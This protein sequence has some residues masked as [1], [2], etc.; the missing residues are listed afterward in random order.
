[1]KKHFPA[2]IHKDPKSDYGVS[3]PDFPGC[4]SAGSTVEEALAM[5]EEALGGHVALMVE[6]GDALPDPS[7]V[8]EVASALDDHCYIAMVPAILPG[9]QKRV[10]ISMDTNLL[11]AIEEVDTNRSRFLSQAAEHELERRRA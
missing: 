6:D 3:F 11:D 8:A 1:M 2:L 10:N 9:K 7:D 5:A 4:F